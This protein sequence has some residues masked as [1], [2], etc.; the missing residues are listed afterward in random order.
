[1]ATASSLHRCVISCDRPEHGFGA[2]GLAAIEGLAGSLAVPGAGKD[3]GLE[4]ELELVKLQK[5]KESWEMDEPEKIAAAEAAKQAGNARFK[6]GRFA[7]AAK[8]YGRALNFV[9]YDSGFGA[10]AI[11]AGCSEV[12]IVLDPG[13]VAVPL[14]DATEALAQAC[15]AACC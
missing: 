9:E 5:A 11:I 1:M 8:K 15:V 14:I 12:P 3:V 6:A 7:A 13:R 2:D 4:W 10:E